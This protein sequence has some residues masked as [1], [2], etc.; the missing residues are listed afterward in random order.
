MNSFPPDDPHL[1]H[2]LQQNRP[3]VPPAAA[4]LE[5]RIFALIDDTPQQLGQI[6]PPS[7]RSR[8]S[9]RVVWL[10]PSA[11][12]AGLVATVVGYQAFVPRQPT[13]AEL[14]ELESFI[15]TTWQGNLAEQPPSETEEL[16]PLTDEA[17]VN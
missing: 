11:I 12:A 5:E 15:E 10:V 3:T 16:L 17:P 1:S 4:D 9:R 6:E 8:P 2:F 7:R 14:A 13:E